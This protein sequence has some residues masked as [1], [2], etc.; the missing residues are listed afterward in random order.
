MKITSVKTFLMQA[1][2]P[3]ETA[4]S[5]GGPAGGLSS[6]GARNWLFVKVYTDAGVTGIGECSG[7]PRVTEMAVRD[8]E[9]V[10]VDQDPAHIERLWQRMHTAMMGHG[11]TGVM[12]YGALAGLD[13]AL[14]DIKG[15]VLDTPVWNLLGGKVRDRIRA[16][17]HAS[18]VESAQSLVARGYTA[19]KTGGVADPLGKL[20]DLRAA[21]GDDIDLMVDLHGPPWL[22]A[23]DAIALCREMERYHPLFVEEPVAPE[24]LA[25]MRRV[26]D[27]TTVPLAA[28]ERLAGLFGQRALIEDDLVDVIQPDTGRS[29]GLTQMR[30]IAALA[31]AHFVGVAP[32][33]GTLGPVAEMAAVHL[34]AAI[35]NAL[36][37]ERFEDDWPG[38]HALVTPALVCENGHLI[39]PDR[40]GL[41]IDIDEDF[42][43]AHPSVRNCRL[44]ITEGSGAYAPGTEDEAVYFQARTARQ[45]YFN[46]RQP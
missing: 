35:P 34:L 25:A 15:K 36:I 18:T 32:H 44:P 19:I 41:G 11:Q 13:M 17:S 3:K 26:R 43:A 16:Y 14:W 29:G 31:E 20:A 27:H 9:H 28:G 2:S 10:I 30:K 4:W 8:L 38:K 24:A 46:R 23:A 37:L 6:A 33:A 5:A 40:P 12:G 1:G 22:N 7:W 21:L 42:I 45:H 39:V